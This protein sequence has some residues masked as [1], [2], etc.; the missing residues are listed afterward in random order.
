MLSNSEGWER[1]RDYQDSHRLTKCRKLV[2]G[3]AKAHI[4]QLS[5]P[6]RE[7]ISVDLHSKR[8]SV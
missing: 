1:P 3:Y 8:I 4:N 2:R 5:V 6:K 7:T